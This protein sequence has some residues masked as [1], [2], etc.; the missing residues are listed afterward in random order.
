MVCVDLGMAC[1]ERISL[2]G[3]LKG[4]TAWIGERGIR[5]ASADALIVLDGERRCLGT[6]DG[7]SVGGN[8]GRYCELRGDG[9]EVVDPKSSGEGDQW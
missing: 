5:L 7:G 6:R 2:S 3:D 9:G 8:A 1:G 4:G